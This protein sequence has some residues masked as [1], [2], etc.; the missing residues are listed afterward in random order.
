[1]EIQ[2]C[3]TVAAIPAV[4]AISVHVIW[5]QVS[6]TPKTSAGWVSL[7]GQSTKQHLASP[8]PYFLQVTDL[9][10]RPLFAFF[11]VELQ[12]RKVIHVGVTRSPSDA[13]TAEPLQEATPYDQTPG[14]L[15]RDHDGKFGPCLARVAAT[16]GI[17]ILNTP[18]HAPRANAICARFLGSVRRE[19]LDQLLI[20]HE[21]QLHRVL[22]AYVVST[23]AQML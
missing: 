22:R 9:L 13:M 20:L 7:A 3:C 23:G 18:D 8:L 6:V 15:I 19:C 1:M 12:S 16:S 2:Y 17:K 21:K 14:Y 10:F 4:V 11:V 5:I